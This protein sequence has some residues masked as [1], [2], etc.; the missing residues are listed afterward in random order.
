MLECFLFV[1]IFLWNKYVRLTSSTCTVLI[2]NETSTSV[3][4]YSVG[5]ITFMLTRMTGTFIGIWNKTM[6]R[7]TSLFDFSVLWSMIESR[8]K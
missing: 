4:I 7:E 6:S 8:L 1:Y 3:T 2:P 5:A